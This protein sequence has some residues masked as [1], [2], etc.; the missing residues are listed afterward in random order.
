M[1]ENKCD[2]CGEQEARF[3]I[4]DEDDESGGSDRRLCR[5][6]AAKA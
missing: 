6:C 3:T 4:E 2:D 1:A 5:D